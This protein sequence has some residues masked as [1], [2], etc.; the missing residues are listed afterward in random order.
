MSEPEVLPPRRTTWTLRQNIVRL[1]WASIGRLAWTLVPPARPALLRTFGGR[2]GRGCRFARTASIYI[3][4]NVQIG[5]RVVVG[6]R[7]MIYTL[8]KVTIGD[9]VVLDERVHL[10]AGTHDM[11]DPRFPLITP[12]ITI[13]PRTKLGFDAYVAPDVTLGADCRVWPRASVYRNFDDGARLR[14]NPAREIDDDAA[15]RPHAPAGATAE[16]AT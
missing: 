9:D 8:G 14:G 6:P 15:D 12:P 4:W 13:G 11:A 7:A 10:C 1:L 5:D 3:P 2:V 16:N